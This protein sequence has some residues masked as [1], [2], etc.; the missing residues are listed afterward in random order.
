MVNAKERE[1]GQ[2]AFRR[3]FGRR[4]PIGRGVRLGLPVAL[5]GELILK[6]CPCCSEQI[7]RKEE[8]RE[9][10]RREF[11]EERKGEEREE[12]RAPVRKREKEPGREAEME[13]SVNL[14]TCTHDARTHARKHVCRGKAAGEVQQ[15]RAQVA[16]S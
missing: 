8:E 4:K 13:V 10:G 11:C 6:H 15:W 16:G 14:R 2:W 3:G 7:S 5:C 1:I 12:A 9:E